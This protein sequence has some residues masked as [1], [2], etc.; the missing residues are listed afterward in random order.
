MP[1]LNWPPSQNQ[2]RNSYEPKAQELEK[3]ALNL[4]REQRQEGRAVAT[5]PRKVPCDAFLEPR[6]KGYSPLQKPTIQIV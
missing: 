5:G 2:G 3:V 1:A 4:G 6:Q